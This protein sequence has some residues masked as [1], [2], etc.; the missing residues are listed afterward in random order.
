MH[1]S[2]TMHNS[3]LKVP[4]VP[5]AV[6]KSQV[7]GMV[8]GKLSVSVQSECGRPKKIWIYKYLDIPKTKKAPRFGGACLLGD[9]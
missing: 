5:C 2:E 6:F 1:G 7:K 8:R 9:A 3:H 4:V